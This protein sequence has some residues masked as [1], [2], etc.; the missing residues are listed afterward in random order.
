MRPM[1][2][3]RA[4]TKSFRRACK[5]HNGNFFCRLCRIYDM[6]IKLQI[7]RG[8]VGFYAIL[9]FRSKRVFDSDIFAVI[10]GI[11]VRVTPNRRTAIVCRLNSLAF[12]LRSRP[13]DHFFRI[14]A[15]EIIVPYLDDLFKRTVSTVFIKLPVYVSKRNVIS[16]R[17]HQRLGIISVTIA[18]DQSKKLTLHQPLSNALHG[19]IKLRRRCHFIS[20]IIK[21]RHNVASS[22]HSQN[23]LLVT[24]R[25]D[26]LDSGIYDVYHDRCSVKSFCGCKRRTIKQDRIMHPDMDMTVILDQA[27]A[28]DVFFKSAFFK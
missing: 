3:G 18:V 17:N 28:Y 27:L 1:I 13:F 2:L 15:S 16:G 23:D 11:T 14:R 6:H 4:C 26:A 7:Q 5:T 9:N 10:I 8:T 20:K 21:D 25:A 19:F 12:P 22:K 24:K